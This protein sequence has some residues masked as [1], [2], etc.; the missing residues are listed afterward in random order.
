MSARLSSAMCPSG[1][2]V[3]SEAINRGLSNVRSASRQVS[4][5]LGTFNLP[6]RSTFQNCL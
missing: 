1:S 5:D 6:Y 4:S 2:A 3:T